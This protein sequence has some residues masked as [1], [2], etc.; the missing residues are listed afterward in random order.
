MFRPDMTVVVD[1]ALN[2]NSDSY[3]ADP[4]GRPGMSDVSPLSG[5]S[6]LSSDSTLLSGLFLRLGED[7]G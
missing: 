5:I 4:E 6:G 7:F 3:S 2:I 1:R